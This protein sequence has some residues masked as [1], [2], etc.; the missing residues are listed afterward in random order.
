MRPIPALLLSLLLL[1]AAAAAA[2]PS[3]S[4]AALLRRA[5]VLEGPR[6]DVRIKKMDTPWR[7]AEAGMLLSGGDRVQ[8]GEEGGAVIRFTDDSV[9]TCGPSTTVTIMPRAA[10]TGKAS[11]NLLQGVLYFFSRAREGELE[12]LTPS[13]I[14]GLRGTEFVLAVDA[15]GETSVD[16]F[17]GRVALG[18][19][20][21]E[22][23]LSGGQ[24]GR[25]A[26]GRPPV[27]PARIDASQALQWALYYPAVLDPD[28]L[29]LGDGERSALAESLDAYR[30]GN[31]L[32]ALAHYPSGIR[33][34][35][36]ETHAY[37]AALVLAVGLTTRA[38]EELD[39]M[40][41]GHRGRLAIERM[42]AA[43]WR[44]AAPGVSAPP[45][46]ASEWLA[47]SYHRQ[48]F[49][50]LEGAREAARAA[51][52]RSPRF[53]FAWVRLAELE[54]G[55][56]RTVEA[57]AALERGR[58][59]APQN[60]HAWVLQGFLLAAEGRSAEA[61]EAFGR[62]LSLDAGL[63]GAWLGRGLVAFRTGD[64]AAGRRDLLA[65][66]ALEPQQ[67]IFHSYLGKAFS[68]LG[69]PSLAARELDRARALDPADPTP[70]LYAA[71]RDVQEYRFNRAIG[72]VTESL[73]LNDNRRV[74][75]S[76][77][78]L[79]QDKAVRSSNLAALYRHN[80]MTDLAVREAARAVESDYANASA[81][82][83]LADSFDALRD[84]T[85]INLRHET[86]WFNE[87]L[88]ASL[89]APVG[90]GPLSQYVSQQEYSQLLEQDGW[91][92]TSISEWRDQGVFDQLA[93][94][95]G[96]FGRFSTGLDLVYRRER[97]TRPNND[98][99]RRELAWQAKIQLSLRDSLYALVKMNRQ[100]GGDL[101]LNP[102]NRVGNGGLRFTDTEAPGLL[103]A[104][105]NHRW[106]P[107]VH[108]LVL[109]SR[110][111]GR[112]E[113]EAPATTQVLLQR[114]AVA[115]EP[116]FL[117]TGAAGAPEY[118]SPEFRQPGAA[119]AVLQ[120]DGSLR[121]SPDFLR[122]IEP[123]LRRGAVTATFGEKFDFSTRRELDIHGAEA[124]HLWQREDNTLVFGGRWQH[125]DFDTGTRLDLLNPVNAGY[126]TAPA[127]AQRQ[128]VGFE[129]RSLYVYDFLH[130]T[131]RL[132]LLG[133]VAWDW[134]ERPENFRNPPVSPL[135]RRDSGT[136]AKAGFTFAPSGA[137]A[138]RGVYAEALGGVTFDDSVRLEPVQLAGFNQAF[139]TVISESL[140][141]SVEAPDYRTVGLS[142]EG[143][144]AGSTWWS[145][146]G[147]ELREKVERSV[148]AFTAF[149]SP[150]FPAG[151][152]ILPSGR[153]ERLDYRERAGRATLNRLFGETWA[154]SLAYG[155]ARAE[156]LQ[157]APEIPVSVNRHAHRCDVGTLHEA[158]LG[159]HWQSPSG[160][161]ARLDGVW[162]RQRLSVSL[163]DVRE[164]GVTGDTF[165]QAH[166]HAGYR[167]SRNRCE[168]SA[169]LLNITDRDYRLSPLNYTQALP[170][171]RTVVVRLRVGF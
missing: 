122:A 110:V 31:L 85:R 61:R 34:G 48:A 53:G 18:N 145:L 136:S 155:L 95:H 55:F 29:A 121:L 9:L 62:A 2:G 119:P 115:L 35:T 69:E 134:M 140:V 63:G 16:M 74:Y 163:A 10:A 52:E 89:L 6:G 120:P 135:S 73:R 118:A 133:G 157:Q 11:L 107:G 142:V 56:G 169:G 123:Y 141:G 131:R 14:A 97:G 68:R 22:L 154:V 13:G 108:T 99:T 165:A 106:S 57:L 84:P 36:A 66:A 87:Q 168:A 126:Y 159:L 79:D 30:A 114:D 149:V 33:P 93:S 70:W 37:R 64:G 150:A 27:G 41:A 5:A 25:M 38:R 46:S 83:L 100:N 139:R 15:G 144:A 19:A 143:R 82:Q 3:G 91:G 90:G 152:V 124:Q 75:R 170:R 72:S 113:V 160:W 112:Q 77:Y 76:R 98:T 102:D 86:A 101:Q 7:R 167:F 88:L 161:F 39:A 132:T 24:R 147:T 32:G 60:A 58:T 94:L 17:D 44:K 78:L 71:I 43:V 138:V 166:V 54:F 105:W 125:G 20:A 116:G 103:L 51:V 109:G 45:A 21:G 49:G 23:V 40:P 164:G 80:G 81:H 158:T 111:S 104:G 47:E 4:E 148:G 162:L 151:A 1:C 26:V 117:R 128:E 65:A 146:T 8:T 59:L 92:G 127:V 96:T 171:E 130:L 50:N 12:V 137:I 156:L 67:A 153:L 129:R 42:L 28:E